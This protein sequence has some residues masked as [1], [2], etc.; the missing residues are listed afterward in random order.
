MEQH[1]FFGREGQAQEVAGRL[2]ERHFVAVVGTSGSGKSSLVRAGLLPL[3]HGGM[4]QQPG[5]RWRISV[6]RPG[7]SPIRNLAEALVFPESFEFLGLFSSDNGIHTSANEKDDIQVALTESVLRRSGVGIMDFFKSA[8][9][10]ENENLLIVVDQFEEIFRF[11][12]TFG[13]QESDEAVAFVKLLLETTYAPESRIYV[14]I[15]MRS[16]FVGDCAQFRDLPEAI[17]NG[18]YLIPRLSREELRSAIESPALV[19]DSSVSPALVNRLLNDLEERQIMAPDRV[20]RDRLPVLQHVLMRMWDRHSA[21][22]NT[23]GS[24]EISDYEDPEIGGM[25]QALS[26]HADEA[27]EELDDRQKIVAEKIFKCLTETDAENRQVRRAARLGEICAVTGAEK[28]DLIEIIEV[29]R[30]KGRTFLMPPPWVPLTDDTTIDIS[31]ESLIRNWETLKEWVRDE[32][33][34]ALEYRRLEGDAGLL[35]RGGSSLWGGRAL[36]MALEWKGSFEPTPAWAERYQHLTDEEKDHLDH[37]RK[38]SLAD[39]KTA[40]KEIVERHFDEV[41]S[42]LQRSAEEEKH[43]EK[44]KTRLVR[45]LKRDRISLLIAVFVSIGLM[46]IILAGWYRD[47]A[48]EKRRKTSREISQNEN[49]LVSDKVKEIRGIYESLLSDTSR[50]DKLFKDSVQDDD[51]AEVFAALQNAYV[52]PFK[53]GA[54]ELELKQNRSSEELKKIDDYLTS[55]RWDRR[56]DTNIGNNSLIVQFDDDGNDSGDVTDSGFD[57]DNPGHGTNSAESTNLDDL[58]LLKNNFDLTFLS[59]NEMKAFEKLKQERTNFDWRGRAYGK[60]ASGLSSIS[61]FT[62]YDSNKL[63]AGRLQYIVYLLSLYRDACEKGGDTVRDGLLTKIESEKDPLSQLDMFSEVVNADS[64]ILDQLSIGKYRTV[65]QNAVGS[66]QI[67]NFENTAQQNVRRSSGAK[68]AEGV[69]RAAAFLTDSGEFG[70]ANEILQLSDPIFNL[71]QSTEDAPLNDQL[72]FV[73]KKNLELTKIAENRSKQETD[74]A[75]KKLAQDAAE[76]FYNNAIQSIKKVNFP[77]IAE[78]RS[79]SELKYMGY[80]AAFHQRLIDSYKAGDIYRQM[81]KTFENVSKKPTEVFPLRTYVTVLKNLGRY[82]DALNQLKQFDQKFGDDRGETL[83][84]TYYTEG[85]SYTTSN[86]RNTAY[87]K[88]HMEVLNGLNRASSSTEI[89]DLQRR[90]RIAPPVVKTEAPLLRTSILLARRNKICESTRY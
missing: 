37:L 44:E 75:L 23:N 84:S 8:D 85:D 21:T 48:V 82:Q 72:Y 34:H 17:N 66:E 30:H 47:Y 6:M 69:F 45:H 49:L 4:I 27:F 5:S 16:D 33:D 20:L 78:D 41:M 90:M 50:I 63:S 2:Q 36:E 56:S 7:G 9:F 60:L 54:E 25:G 83:N 1:L 51:L 42:F 68:W 59:K 12:E 14:V 22:A 18:Q 32:A 86:R 71:L 81:E 53:S 11:R 55:S 89:L 58:S 65:I 35:D 38:T 79:F 10:A 29:F 73:A 3:L 77:N 40:R 64:A 62:I 70:Q 88:D 28:K 43:K 15:T 74:P 61:S 52:A 46:L 26:I 67:K 80:Q 57:R 87:Y 76:T 31:H 19:C 13:A 39:E 24:L